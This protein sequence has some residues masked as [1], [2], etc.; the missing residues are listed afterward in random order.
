MSYIDLLFRPDLFF[1]ELMQKGASLKVPLIIIII[2][3]MITAISAGFIAGIVGEALPMDLEGLGILMAAFAG[4]ISIIAVFVIWVIWAGVFHGISSI[5]GGKGG[6][7][8]V[9]EVVG[10]GYLPQVFSAVIAAVVTYDYI[11]TLDLTALTDPE[12]AAQFQTEMLSDPTIQ[13]SSIVGIIF[14]LWSA[15]IWIFG[16]REAHGISTRNALIA[17]GLP[18]LLYILFFGVMPLLGSGGV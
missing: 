15:N 18:V 5:L 17:V 9:L 4:I 3:A 2:M 14:L 8:R 6:F 11:G 10:Y 16:I 13:F 7:K 1:K 12:A